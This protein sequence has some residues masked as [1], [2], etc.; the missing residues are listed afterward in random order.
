MAEGTNHEFQQSLDADAP[1]SEWPDTAQAMWYETKG[2]WD[3]A[4]QIVQTS[5]SREAARV[6]ALLHRIEG[7]LSNARYWY[8]RAECEE[9]TGS[10][11]SERAY[12]VTRLLGEQR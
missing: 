7:D 4:H 6:H 2:D 9:F 8:R 11:D 1:P 12:L 10:V 5:D 3:R